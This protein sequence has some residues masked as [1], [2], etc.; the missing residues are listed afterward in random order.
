M[1]RHQ[2][3]FKTASGGP[4]TVDVEYQCENGAVV[5]AKILG[6]SI[7]GQETGDFDA[8]SALKEWS[9]HWA[10]KIDCDGETD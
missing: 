1:G 5:F 3:E 6:G 4:V 2:F 8:Y 10:D 9:E 7:N